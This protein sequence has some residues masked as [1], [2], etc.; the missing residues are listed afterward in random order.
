MSFASA[1]GRPRTAKAIDRRSS[2]R[3]LIEFIV[4]EAKGS[5]R[6]ETG[7]PISVDSLAGDGQRC[8]CSAVGI[9]LLV[10]ESRSGLGV[11]EGCAAFN[12]R[13]VLGGRAPLAFC[14]L[15]AELL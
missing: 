7:I 9:V 15:E 10:I 1:R 5:V 8:V 12:S 3:M 2:R 11:Q 13:F 6:I 14:P 4:R